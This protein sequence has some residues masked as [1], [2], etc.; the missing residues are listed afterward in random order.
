[1]FQKQA[2]PIE[3]R[4][5]ASDRDKLR[6]LCQLDNHQLMAL[7]DQ[8]IEH[9]EPDGYAFDEELFTAAQQLLN[10]RAPI[11]H[12]VDSEEMLNRFFTQ[13]GPLLNEQPLDTPI[14]NLRRPRQKLALRAV[15]IAVSILI[16]AGSVFALATGKNPISETLNL[17]EHLVQVIRFGESGSMEL[18]ASVDG[19]HTLEEAYSAAGISGTALKWVP[20]DFNLELI[21]VSAEDG[22]V[23]SIDA[24]WEGPEKSLLLHI[25]PVDNDWYLYDEKDEDIPSEYVEAHGQ[26]FELFDNNGWLG[27]RWSHNSLTYL[28]TGNITRDEAK[29]IISTVKLEE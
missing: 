8:I 20:S 5:A 27:V 26:T 17:G 9:A 21:N 11:D 3:A 2:G 19:Y 7:M 4:L 24:F 22:H 25:A 12:H 18:P 10:E 16:G 29:Q 23:E 13:Y 15:L 14:R 6:N 28:L 1:M